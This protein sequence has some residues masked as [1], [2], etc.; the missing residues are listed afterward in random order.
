MKKLILISFLSLILYTGKAQKFQALTAIG[1]NVAQVDGDRAYG[2][3]KYGLNAGVGAIV[4]FTPKWSLHIETMFSQKGSRQRQQST[5]DS[6]TGELKLNLN[7][8][9][10][11]LSINFYDPRGRITIGTGVSWGRLVGFSEFQNGY[12][13]DHEAMGVAMPRQSN[14]DWFANV[15][16]PLRG[17]FKINARYVYSIVPIRERI[18]TN[19]EVRKQYHNLLTFRLVYVF[20]EK[21]IKKEKKK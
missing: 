19:S 4:P 12:N 9:E 17:H 1:F 2:F 18:F 11:P 14:I 8:V 3:H 7:Y 15:F 21:D 10:V 6:L 13:I 5:Q 20:G 16:I